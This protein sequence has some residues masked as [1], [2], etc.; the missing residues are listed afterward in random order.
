MSH[1]VDLTVSHDL[2][3]DHQSRSLTVTAKPFL[4]VDQVLAL[5]GSRK[6]VGKN[7]SY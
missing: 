4:W 5:C 2:V 7:G 3:F 6:A 1:P